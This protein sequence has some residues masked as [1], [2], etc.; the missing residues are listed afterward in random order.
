MERWFLGL[1]LLDGLIG[2]RDQQVLALC[3]ELPVQAQQ[4][5]IDM[6]AIELD[7][8][9]CVRAQVEPEVEFLAAD[10]IPK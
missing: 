1:N 8:R 7:F 10:L 5:D 6:V 4:G 3:R 2:A 9:T